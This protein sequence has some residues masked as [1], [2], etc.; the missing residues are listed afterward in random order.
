MI[1]AGVPDF[2]AQAWFGVFA[3]AGTPRP[4]INRLHAEMAAAL[5][6]PAV[7]ERLGTLG[8]DITVGDP[9]QLGAL[10]KADVEKWRVVIQ[11]AGIDKV[12]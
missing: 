4:V 6:L 8:V 10:V 9:E 12:D 3:P 11:K 5:A 7:R 2:E 1:E